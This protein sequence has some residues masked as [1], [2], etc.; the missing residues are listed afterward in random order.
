LYNH[1]QSIC[2][3][4]GRNRNKKVHTWCWTY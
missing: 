4:K 3:K 2:V 1:L